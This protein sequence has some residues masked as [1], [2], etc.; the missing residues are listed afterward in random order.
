M[1]TDP[2]RREAG[3]TPNELAR[4]LRVSPDRVRHWIQSGELKAI[5]TSDRRCGR[6]R[7]VILPAALEEFIRSRSVAAPPK[8]AARRPRLSAVRDYYP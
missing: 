3:M 8:P 5:D 6:P 7:F 2:A 1:A 4:V